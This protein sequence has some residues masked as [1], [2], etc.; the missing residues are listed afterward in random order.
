MF[1][2]VRRLSLLLAAGALLT[3]CSA[4]GTA[5]ATTPTATSDTGSGAL[6]IGSTSGTLGTY[7]TGAEG[8]T[9]Y[10]FTKD[11]PNA[12]TC[13]GTCAQTWPALTVGNG[14]AP[15][16]GSGVTGMLGTFARTDG[17]TQVTVGGMPLYYYSGDSKAGDTNGQGKLGVWFVAPASGQLNVPS[18]APSTTPTRDPYGY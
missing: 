3:A 14:Q 6:A 18:S 5:P 11:S 12:S 2:P 15:Q 13:S 10:V 7:L 4:V 1:A 9:L 8:R 16:A 17:T